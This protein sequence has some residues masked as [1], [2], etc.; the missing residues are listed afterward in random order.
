MVC[1]LSAAYLDHRFFAL[2]IF[3]QV[4]SLIPPLPLTLSPAHS[5]LTRTSSPSTRSGNTSTRSLTGYSATPVFTWNAHECHGHTTAS[6]SSHP[7]PSGPCR[8]GQTLS[9]ADNTPFTFARQTATP[10]TSASATC[11]T[12]GVSARPHNL[13][14]LATRNFSVISMLE[15]PSYAND[16]TPPIS[17]C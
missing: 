3:G 17:R 13:T 1:K 15:L 6:P 14:H 11:P 8:C 2:R 5:I 9:S 7:C 12:A 16:S 4:P 10:S